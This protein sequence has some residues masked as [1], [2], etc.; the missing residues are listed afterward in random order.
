MMAEYIERV[1]IVVGRWFRFP[2]G[3]MQ[4]RLFF[5][6]TSLDFNYLLKKKIS[7]HED[8]EH[9]NNVNLKKK[10]NYEVILDIFN[11]I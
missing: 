10:N 6:I 2:Q 5:Q 7:E 4:A 1:S 3:N 11:V 9:E 8:I